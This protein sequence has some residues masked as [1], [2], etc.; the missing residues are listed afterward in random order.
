MALPA[1]MLGRV[2]VLVCDCSRTRGVT[3]SIPQA[4]LFLGRCGEGRCLAEIEAAWRLG[5]GRGEWGSDRWR[6][7]S[8]LTRRLQQE[9]RRHCIPTSSR[10][11][12]HRPVRQRHPPRNW[13]ASA[14][15]PLL[16]QAAQR[17]TP[18]LLPYSPHRSSSSLIQLLVC[19]AADFR[20]SI[21][22]VPP[23]WPNCR[24]L[25]PLHLSARLSAA[26][27][28]LL[29]HCRFV[30]RLVSL[31]EACAPPCKSATRFSHTQTRSYDL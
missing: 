9:I 14:Q 23:S 18:S 11:T 24:F 25:H 1:C 6:A 8:L 22:P 7:G 29:V 28:R 30:A 19:K 31:V 2:S 15:L 12:T 26:L 13:P 4:F 10:F 16:C 20:F 3:T 5:E 21:S 17:Q 27:T